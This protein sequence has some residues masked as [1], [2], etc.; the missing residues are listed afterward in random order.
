MGFD[1]VFVLGDNRNN[2]SDSQNWGMLPMEA[3]I[4]KAIFVYWP[5]NEISLIPHYDLAV[6]AGP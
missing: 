6:A 2:S 1:E 3:V 5:I 4:G